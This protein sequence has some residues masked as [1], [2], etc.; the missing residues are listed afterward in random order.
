MLLTNLSASF[1]FENLPK[2][3]AKPSVNEALPLLSVKA[4]ASLEV[5]KPLN[6][7]VFL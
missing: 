5:L 7:C 3:C 2:A 6:D 1:V 4:F